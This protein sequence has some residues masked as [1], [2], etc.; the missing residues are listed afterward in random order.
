MLDFCC[1]RSPQALAVALGE[2]LG[3]KAGV[4]STANLQ[5]AGMINR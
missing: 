2:G 3:G 1:L 5:A 4:A